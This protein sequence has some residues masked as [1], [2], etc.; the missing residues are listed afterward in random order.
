[1]RRRSRNERLSVRHTQDLI[2]NQATSMAMTSLEAT[3]ND[4]KLPLASD[5][6]RQCEGLKAKVGHVGRESEVRLLRRNQFRA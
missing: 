5:F 3:I 2:C 6:G 4:E 1:M